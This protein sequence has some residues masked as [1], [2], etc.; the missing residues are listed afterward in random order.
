[1]NDNNDTKGKRGEL[2]PF[3]YYKVFT[4]AIKQYSAFESGLR[5]SQMYM[6]NTRA[7]TKE[8]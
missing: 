7:N 6:A 5:F 1:M 2:N 3:C 4:P 8:K